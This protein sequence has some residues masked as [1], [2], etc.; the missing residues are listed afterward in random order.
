MRTVSNEFKNQI[1]EF[2]RELSLELQCYPSGTTEAHTMIDS[3]IVSFNLN[4]QLDLF[5]TCLSTVDLTLIGK[6]YN[7]LIFSTLKNGSITFVGKLLIPENGDVAEHWEEFDLGT[8]YVYATEYDYGKNETKLECYDYMI[9]THGKINYDDFDSY[10]FSTYGQHLNSVKLVNIVN[11]VCTKCGLFASITNLINNITMNLSFIKEDEYSYRDLLDYIAQI[12]GCSF[13][14]KDKTLYSVYPAITKN[15]TNNRL[16]PTSVEI[17]ANGYNLSSVIV[18]ERVG[19]L[20]SF[21]FIGTKETGDDSKEAESY[22]FVYS[23]SSS[24]SSNGETSIIFENNPII[25]AYK[26]DAN[27]IATNLYNKL[28]EFTY[29]VYNVATFGF[30]YLEALDGIEV[31]YAESKYKTLILD[32]SVTWNGGLTETFS[33][34]EIDSSSG[35][36]DYSAKGYAEKQIDMLNNA[37]QRLNVESIKA[38]DIEAETGK[39]NY[40]STDK[41]N[42]AYIQ[43]EELDA[44]KADIKEAVIEEADIDYARIDFANIDEAWV[45]DLM[46]Q[47]KIIAQE[48]SFYYLD[49]VNVNAD[50]ITAGKLRVDQLLV[51]GDDNEYYLVNVKSDGTTENVKLE[52]NIVKDNSLD[53]TKIIAESITADRIAANTITANNLATD[54]IKSRNYAEKS[55]GETLQGTFLNLQDGSIKSKNFNIDENGNARF[56]GDIEAVTGKIGAGDNYLLMQNGSLLGFSGNSISYM[57]PLNLTLDD[58]EFIGFPDGMTR[59]EMYNEYL[60]NINTTNYNSIVLLPMV[61]PGQTTNIDYTRFGSISSSS[62]TKRDL[63]LYENSFYLSMYDKKTFYEYY[64]TVFDTSYTRDELK[65]FTSIKNRLAIIKGI[66]SIMGKFNC[67]QPNLYRAVDDYLVGKPTG[68]VLDNDS[69]EFSKTATLGNTSM[70][71]SVD[72]GFE[73]YHDVLSEEDQTYNYETLSI[74][75]PQD[76][77]G[78][79]GINMQIQQGSANSYSSNYDVNAISFSR[80]EEGGSQSS[81]SLSSYNNNLEF[82]SLSGQDGSEKTT[83]YGINGITSTS[84]LAINQGIVVGGT[85]KATGSIVANN[86]SS[87]I[88]TVVNSANSSNKTLTSTPQIVSSI[89]LDTGAWVIVAHIRVTPGTACYL[90]GA[91][92]DATSSSN[93]SLHFRYYCGATSNYE[94]VVH[95]I[96]SVSANTTMNLWLY[97]NQTNTAVVGGGPRVT[98]LMAVRIA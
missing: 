31:E 35:P 29:Y 43:T 5:R 71:L 18:N 42:A 72:R 14:V 85:V 40:L 67:P 54:S 80:T 11:S 97:S 33:A 41:L 59:E 8:Y 47:G 27:V 75:T 64:N 45:K 56:A 87:A 52:G 82:Y 19:P 53:G 2:G 23:N 89:P 28:G 17:L 95:D 30:G 10:V 94:I 6:D 73:Y 68:M 21:G 93:V 61:L 86:H 65:L 78:D 49:A 46:V 3:Q 60:D 39:F 57:L 24:I 7:N 22:K 26:G 48:G 69:L 74:N 50:K 58:V 36:N 12:S 9:V 20:N 96:V 32:Y 34:P 15:T 76:Y 83:T 84:A 4:T 92:S 98:G 77:I 90:S 70:N 79:L 63:L 81:T 25:S 66:G 88:G 37:Y 1:T 62:I 16:E 44:I 91:I 13:I 38:R 55:T 51:K